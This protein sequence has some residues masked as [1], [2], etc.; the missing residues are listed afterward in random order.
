MDKNG[1][2]TDATI[3]EHIHKLLQRKYA[4]KRAAR[5][6][7]TRLGVA[8]VAAFDTLGL[9]FSLTQPFIRCQLEQQLSGV[10][11]GEFEWQQVRERNCEMFR[12]VY[13]RMMGSFGGPMMAAF[14]KYLSGGDGVDGGEFGGGN[15]FDAMPVRG[16]SG[17]GGNDSDS[18]TG[19]SGGRRPPK[20]EGSVRGGVGEGRS[21]NRSSRIGRSSSSTAASNAPSYSTASYSTAS[22][23]TASHSNPPIP[24]NPSNCKCGVETVK[25]TVSKDGPNRGRVFLTCGRGYPAQCDYFEWVDGASGSNGSDWKEKENKNDNRYGGNNGSA[26]YSSYNSNSN[27]NSYRYPPSNTP[28]I[29]QSSTADLDDRCQCGL[30]LIRGDCKKGP[31]AG[32]AFLICPK[33]VYKCG[34][35]VWIDGGESLAGNESGPRKRV[36]SAGKSTGKSNGKSTGKSKGKCYKCNKTGHWATECPN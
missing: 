28:S 11:A 6:I 31:N 26:S 23:S 7:P 33:Q 17:G 21:T 2:G 29:T 5:F 14:K 20:R 24:A 12:G 25:R 10:C 36:K 3:H 35:F 34:R 27:Y 32:R 22:F 18:D 16:S 8:L 15:P 30:T 1:I 19:G 13:G 4:V 9:Q